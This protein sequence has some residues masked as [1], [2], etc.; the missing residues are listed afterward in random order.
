MVLK[1]FPKD[2]SAVLD[3]AFDWVALGWLASDETISDYTI[4]VSE[5]LT[6]DSDGELNGIVTVWL[7]GGTAGTD[8][9]VACEITTSE[10]RTEERTIT[11]RCR[12][13]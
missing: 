8:Y 3:Y 12:D 13:R 6:K 1:S 4:T 5:G 11:I 2:P 9:T 10:G 7:S